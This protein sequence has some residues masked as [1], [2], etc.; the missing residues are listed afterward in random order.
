[1]T[2]D[3]MDHPSWREQYKR[4]KRWRPRLSEPRRHEES[5]EEHELRLGDDV[6]AFFIECYHLVDWLVNDPAVRLPRKEGDRLVHESNWLRRCK[7]VCDGSKHMIVKKGRVTLVGGE[8]IEDE[9]S[10]VIL[11]EAGEAILNE[12]MTEVGTVEGTWEAREMADACI[13]EWQRILR[14][15]GLPQHDLTFLDEQDRNS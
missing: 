4:V 15:I 11:D 12:R 13:S 1:V 14:R 3:H 7:D 10:D 5:E 9:A 2:E 6:R 8:P